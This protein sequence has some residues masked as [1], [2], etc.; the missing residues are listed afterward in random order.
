[1]QE[2]R[3]IDAFYL[4]IP[5]YELNPK[6]RRYLVLQAMIRKLQQLKAGGAFPMTFEGYKNIVSSVYSNCLVLKKLFDIYQ[7]KVEIIYIEK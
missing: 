6:N 5:W 7:W 2:K 1:M 3:V 4:A